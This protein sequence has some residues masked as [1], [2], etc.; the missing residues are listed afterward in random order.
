M[1]KF[2]LLFTISFLVLS[3]NGQTKKKE[4]SSKSESHTETN[5]AKI[6]RNN[7]AVIWS[8][9]NI[10]LV[11]NYAEVI[12]KEFTDLYENDIIENAYFDAESTKDKPYSFPNIVCF[13]KAHSKEDATH[14]L[15]KLT[16]V[17]KGVA[18]YKLYPVGMLWL[19]RSPD[20]K[21]VSKAYVSVWTDKKIQPSNKVIKAQYDKVLDLWNTGIIENVYFNI[22]GLLEENNKTDFMFF[23]NADTEE[24]A[25]EVCKSL[26]FYKEKKATFEVLPVGVFWYGRNS[27]FK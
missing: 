18:T 6:G 26:P 25:E 22:E 13:L 1:Q 20:K 7:Y 24:A 15:E 8:T 16:L 21:E 14:F 17:R 27:N 3:C 9:P 4:L 12:S 11:V 10:D 19:P 2:I 23:I 5:T